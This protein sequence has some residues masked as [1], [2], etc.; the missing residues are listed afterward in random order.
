MQA[1]SNAKSLDWAGWLKGVISAI[2]SGGAGAFG[3]SLGAIMADPEHFSMNTGSGL[4][5]V[6][7]VAGYAFLVSA[8]V[9]L[10]KYLQTAPIPPEEA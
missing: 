8:A 3:G 6:F 9:S 5:D 10:A 4:H 2:V 7:T 1:I